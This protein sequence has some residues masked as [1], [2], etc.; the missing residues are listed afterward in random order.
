MMAQEVQTAEIAVWFQYLVCVRW[1]FVT[2]CPP[3]TNAKFVSRFYVFLCCASL[4]SY[5]CLVLLFTGLCP[6][7][8]WW[9]GW[10]SGSHWLLCI[11]DFCHALS[12]S[13]RSPELI[14]GYYYWFIC[15]MNIQ[16]FGHSWLHFVILVAGGSWCG[17]Q[18]E[19]RCENSFKSSCSSVHKEERDSPLSWWGCSL[20]KF[21]LYCVQHNFILLPFVMHFL[22]T[23]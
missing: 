13:I 15:M 16:F 12:A 10:N 5:F 11:A 4:F 2:L 7:G 6:V 20:R 21:I 1:A 19:K 22:V 18:D 14:I 8:C 17:E 23:Q 9:P 3:G